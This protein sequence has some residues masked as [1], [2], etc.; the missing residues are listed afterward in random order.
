MTSSRS[1]EVRVSLPRSGGKS[2]DD[3]RA[4]RFDIDHASWRALVEWFTSPYWS[5]PSSLVDLLE[6]SERGSP[7]D[8]PRSGWLAETD[9]SSVIGA[10]AALEVEGVVDTLVDRFVFEGRDIEGAVALSDEIRRHRPDAVVIETTSGELVP[11]SVAAVM[12][13][14][15]SESLLQGFPAE[16]LHG[17]RSLLRRVVPVGSGEC[18]GAALLLPLSALLPLPAGLVARSRVRG[19]PIGVPLAAYPLA[20]MVLPEH[21]P[22]MFPIDEALWSLLDDASVGDRCGR[23]VPLDRWAMLRFRTAVVLSRPLAR[24]V[25]VAVGGAGRWLG[26]LV[27]CA[28]RTRL[29]RRLVE[30]GVNVEWVW[31]LLRRGSSAA[32]NPWM[33]R[34]ARLRLDRNRPVRRRR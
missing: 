34:S 9:L 23:L 5:M 7:L 11:A 6:Q 32:D 15:V 33:T 26:R 27:E 2:V 29:G 4:L 25:R 18:D 10:I 30:R 20:A 13:W 3:V 21:S 12:A 14:I 8:H 22:R 16:V 31:S 17:H 1:P 19:L 24:P 28:T